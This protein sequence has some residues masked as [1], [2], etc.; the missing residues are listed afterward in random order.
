MG[1]IGD[2]DG[3]KGD[4]KKKKL[5]QSSLLFFFQNIS[6][7]IVANYRILLTEKFIISCH[8]LLSKKTKCSVNKW[9]VQ[10]IF[11]PNGIYLRSDMCTRRF[12][13]WIP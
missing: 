3:R 5:F 6:L 1:K 2:I 9:Q 11:S 4:K 7:K 10:K 13:L 12:I 8:K